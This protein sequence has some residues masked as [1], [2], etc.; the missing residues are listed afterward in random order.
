MAEQTARSADRP[1]KRSWLR[2]LFGSGEPRAV[3][4]PLI[5]PLELR[6]MK[7]ALIVRTPATARRGFL[8]DDVSPLFAFGFGLSFTS[9]HFAKVRLL[10]A[11]VKATG[12]TR[13]LVDVTNAGEREGT[14][15]VQLYIRDLVSS[16]TRPVKELKGFQRVNLKPGETRTV[17]FEIKPELLRFYDINMKYRVEAGEFEVMVGNSS[18]DEDLQKVILTVTE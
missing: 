3:T 4:V 5:T 10:K 17:E 2:G 14:E 11:T 18:R 13:V 12:S 6:N 15:V 16:V 8:W 1:A 7:P 9:F